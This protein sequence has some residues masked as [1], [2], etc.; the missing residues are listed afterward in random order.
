MNILVC[1]GLVHFLAFTSVTFFSVL[2]VCGIIRTAFFSAFQRTHLEPKRSSGSR[3][4]P[5]S[6]FFIVGN[7]SQFIAGNGFPLVPICPV[8]IG[9]ARLRVGYA[10]SDFGYHPSPVGSEQVDSFPSTCSGSQSTESTI[11][12][13]LPSATGFMAQTHKEA[14]H[15]LHLQ[16]VVVQFCEGALE[17]YAKFISQFE[18]GRQTTAMTAEEQS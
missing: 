7:H 10:V 15:F 1:F 11:R 2:V 3:S 9:R 12:N 16:H 4:I 6:L 13:Q 5:P 8:L 14:P 18:P 17:T